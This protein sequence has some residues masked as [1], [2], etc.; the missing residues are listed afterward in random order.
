MRDF[1]GR[2]KETHDE[3]SSIF[4]NFIKNMPIR[5]A[6]DIDLNRLSK[7]K[8]DLFGRK[9]TIYDSKIQQGQS[10]IFDIYPRF[11]NHIN[12]IA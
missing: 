10:L 7:Y 9:T 5:V 1:Q 2:G 11:L 12:F 6:M 3:Y 8:F 4:G